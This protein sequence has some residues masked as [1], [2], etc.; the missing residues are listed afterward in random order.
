MKRVICFFI[1]VP[2]FSTP[3]AWATKSRL[4]ALGQNSS[5]SFYI[6]DERNIF[7]N[8]A[9]IH[10][11]DRRLSFEWGV[12]G[13]ADKEDT[14]AAPKGEGGWWDGK[15]STPYAIYLGNENAEAVYVRNIFSTSFLKPDNTIDVTWGTN[16]GAANRFGFGIN[17]SK[18]VDEATGGIDR[19]ETFAGVRAGAYLGEDLEIFGILHLFDEA[20]GAAADDDDYKGEMGLQ[21]SA[22]YNKERYRFYGSL[23]KKGAEYTPAS[24]ST[25]T[26]FGS[27]LLMAGAAHVEDFANRSM[28][29]YFSE[30]RSWNIEM[31]S[32][33]TT[34]K[35]DILDLKFGL[36]MEGQVAKWLSLRG[37]VAQA[38]LL[39]DYK[40][41][42]TGSSSVNWSNPDTTSVAC[43]MTLRF[44]GFNLDGSFGT[45]GGTL[46]GGNIMSRVAMSYVY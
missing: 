18:N 27:L 38:T 42:L 28:I 9:Y 46:T 6:Q 41:K 7:L 36:G 14:I 4:E 10:K 30:L 40:R 25:S 43:G 37:S 44:N 26:D 34:E 21:L 3:A 13:T 11:L 15:A 22:I 12:A 2:F 45:S 16:V 39:N 20:D 1:C 33:A 29:F 24:S 32:G 31:G 19:S 8:P 23:F 17:Y 5:G 35:M